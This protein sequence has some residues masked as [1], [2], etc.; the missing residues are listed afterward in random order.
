[1]SSSLR[2]ALIATAL[3]AAVGLAGPARAADRLEAIRVSDV[4]GKLIVQGPTDDSA[5]YLELNS[6]VRAQDTLWTDDESRAELELGRSSW[7]RLSEG[8]KLD[9][10]ALP[11]GA[12][13]RLWTGSCILDVSDRG[14]ADWTIKLP[15]GEAVV[16]PDS[17]TRIDVASDSR[18]RVTVFNGRVRLFG[19]RGEPVRLVKGERAFLSAERGIEDILRSGREE[20]AFDAYHRSRVEYYISRPLPEELDGDLLGARELSDN[21]SW[22]VVD[23]VRYWRPRC[24]PGWRPYSNG[25]WTF[26]P[27]AGY[28]FVDYAPWGYT[29]CHYGRWLWRPAFGWLWSPGSSWGSSFVVWSTFGDYCGWAPLDPWDRP[30]YYGYGNGFLFR[31]GFGNVFVDYR[32]WTFCDITRFHYGRHHRRLSAGNPI[33]VAGNDISLNGRDLRLGQDALS[34]IGVPLGGVRGITS[35]GGRLARERIHTV[36]S[37]MSQTALKR[38]AERYRDGDGDSSQ[39]RGSRNGIAERVQRTPGEKVRDEEVVR[40]SDALRRIGENRL[41]GNPAAGREPADRDNG[42]P[43]FPIR[44]LTG[45]GPASAPQRDRASQGDSDRRGNVITTPTNT[46][47]RP[48]GASASDELRPGVIFPRPGGILPPVFGG[49]R[50]DEPRSLPP[51]VD[52]RDRKDDRRDRDNPFRRGGPGQSDRPNLG[53]GSDRPIPVPGGPRPDVERPRP[54]PLPSPPTPV[55]TLPGIG[56]GA[57]GPRPIPGVGSPAPVQPTRPPLPPGLGS[58][59][60]GGSSRPRVS[61]LPSPAPPIP[62]GPRSD[63]EPGLGRPGVPSNSNPAGPRPDRQP[64]TPRPIPTSPSPSRGEREPAPSRPSPSPSR[65]SDSSDRGGRDRDRDRGSNGGGRSGSES[66]GGGRSGGSESRGPAS[67]GGRRRP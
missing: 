22:V 8:S 52:E 53:S 3:G 27:G 1:M 47:P 10:R 26:L 45:S 31:G 37:R 46:A 30:C 65:G 62:T 63:R 64:P 2:F 48:G 5:T 60:D 42:N 49:P 25:Y 23:S 38:L 17:V 6:T 39:R 4:R 12:E 14:G 18:V 36:E 57:I 50:R 32:S 61:P 24:E 16:S 51:R 40:G 21:G 28:S 11:P 13:F 29:T 9:V 56:G 44:S 20:D 7:L 41:V 58:S 34:R 54:R 15:V 59:S 33:F 66:S 35:D 67:D 19:D 43:G 55:E